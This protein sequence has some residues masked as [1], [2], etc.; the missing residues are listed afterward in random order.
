MS[1][2]R[3]N[4]ILKQIH[5]SSQENFF[6]LRDAT[7][8]EAQE[9][10]REVFAFFAGAPLT[11]GVSRVRTV[12]NEH[13]RRE[14]FL[15]SH[16]CAFPQETRMC[17]F[18]VKAEI[19]AEAVAENGFSSVAGGKCIKLARAANVEHAADYGG[20]QWFVICR[21]QFGREYD[22]SLPGRKLDVRPPVDFDSSYDPQVQVH[23]VFEPARILPLFLVEADVRQ[24]F[25]LDLP[26]HWQQDGILPSQGFRCVVLP[27]SMPEFK[28]LRDCLT[29]RSVDLGIGRDVVEKGRYSKLE[30]S[31]AWRIENHKLWARYAVERR[32]MADEIRNRTI[33]LPRLKL[34]PEFASAIDKLPGALMS[35]VNETRLLHGTAPEVV[36]TMLSNGPN[37]RFSG[38]LFGHGTYLAEDAGKNDQYVTSDKAAGQVQDLHR[39]L[40]PE[41]VATHPGTVYY[42]FLCRVALGRYVETKQ[43]GEEAL[44]VDEKPVYATTARRELGYI[45]GLDPPLHYHSLL[46]ELGGQIQRYREFV[47]FHDVRI[48]PEYLLAYRR[49]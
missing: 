23:G 33:R 28:A 20:R 7:V 15:A 37:E 17:S 44:S 22:C 19:E 41:G 12:E 9:A 43:G 35:E 18:K 11:A 34:R 38:G 2:E 32:T 8:A 49:V 48:Y 21:V 5:E 6:R 39:R 36:L 30:L 3:K 16:S 31:R 10:K 26:T 4:Q 13:L 47:V 14:F 27:P 42:L 1:E 46:A 25:S 29:T 24:E 45:P 40:Y